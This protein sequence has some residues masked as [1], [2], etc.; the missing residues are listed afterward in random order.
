MIDKENRII[1]YATLIEV[2][3]ESKITEALKKCGYE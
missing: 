3:D 1:Y 2:I